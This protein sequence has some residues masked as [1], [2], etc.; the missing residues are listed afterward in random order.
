MGFDDFAY[1][2]RMRDL[3]TS[4]A[5]STIERLR[6]EARIGQVVELNWLAKTASVITVQ[7]K[8]TPI[9]VKTPYSEA[10][11]SHVGQIV[12]FT[13]HPGSFEVRRLLTPGKWLDLTLES[14]FAEFSGFI[15]QVSRENGVVY[16]RGAVTR[17]AAANGDIVAILEE[18][19]RPGEEFRF[20]NDSNP[21]STSSVR[22]TISNAG[23]LRIYE[24]TGT[25]TSAYIHTS[26]RAEA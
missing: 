9:T 12:E 11:P 8:E 23:E 7:D 10:I 21:A 13:G 6:P 26:Y 5:E 15:P 4:I 16:L 20:V 24:K 22:A 3:I 2:M 17:N 19:F 18:G 14:P 25:W 1:A